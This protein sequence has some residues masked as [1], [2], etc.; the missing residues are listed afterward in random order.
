MGA[1][2]HGAHDHGSHGH[3]DGDTSVTRLGVASG[4]NVG[5]AVVQVVV[6]LA[7]GSVAVLADAAHQVVDALG[8][9]TALIAL[10]LA[11]RPSDDQMSYG[12]GKA[13]AL[14]GLLSAVLLL[15][16]VGWIVLE[17]VER[18]REPAEVSGVGVI[19]IGL[20]G[21]AVN[22]G[23][24]VLVGHG[25]QLSVKAARLHLLTDLAGSVIVVVT[26]F[27]LAAGGWDGIDP[28]ASL[29]LSALVLH[30]TWR[31]ARNAVDELLDRTPAAVTPDAI[32]GALA[33]LGSVT[34]VHHVHSRPLG[35]GKV[36][37]TAHVVV[38]GAQSLHEAQ[39][40]IDEVSARLAERLGVAHTT[41]QLECHD[42]DAP[43][44]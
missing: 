41:L 31:L 24:V 17:A 30:A 16:S 28:L 34:D 7:L 37:V 4:I 23:S 11:R 19:A 3:G 21:I 2:D 39:A 12:W 6:G 36:S 9:V 35:G 22:G 42:C 8:L 33:D 27:V 1:H 20:A 13:D 40:T 29:V 18:L 14:G 15:V 43:E 26:G 32:R 10:T 5:F 25:H 44:H 38:D